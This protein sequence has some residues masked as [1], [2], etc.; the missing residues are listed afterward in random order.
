MSKFGTDILKTSWRHR[1]SGLN[2]FNVTIRNSG[3]WMVE[4][5]WMVVNDLEQ[6]WTKFRFS[7][8]RILLNIFRHNILMSP[9][10]KELW[11]SYR[12]CI[13]SLVEILMTHYH[14]LRKSFFIGGFRFDCVVDQTKRHVKSHSKHFS[15]ERFD[16]NSILICPFID[17]CI[18]LMLSYP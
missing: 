2:R 6:S 3:I 10:P 18:F 13:E 12:K 9:N 15:T 5:S 11:K 8:S 16:Q 4:W 7:K 17:V 14:G 1:T